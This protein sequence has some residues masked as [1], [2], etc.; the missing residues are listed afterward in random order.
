LTAI[1]CNGVNP[2][3]SAPIEQIV[4]SG[5]EYVDVAWASHGLVAL[6]WD[7]A[8]RG[9]PTRPALDLISLDSDGSEA[10]AVD[11]WRQCEEDLTVS[12][13]TT[14]AR[15][16]T[17][18][19]LEWCNTTVG[20]SSQPGVWLLDGKGN[21]SLLFAPPIAVIQGGQL[22]LTRDGSSGFF[23]TGSRI[24]DG[25]LRIDASR[26]DDPGIVIS[27]DR[28]G[29]TI[30]ASALG[31]SELCDSGQ[32][33]SPDIS[34]DGKTLALFASP[35][36]VRTTG[37]DRL[38]VPFDIYLIDLA[39]LEV[40]R[41]PVSVRD[42]RDLRWSPVGNRLAFTGNVDGTGRSLTVLELSSRRR[43]VIRGRVEGG[44]SWS[45]DA[46]RIASIVSSTPDQADAPRR[47]S[48][49]EVPPGS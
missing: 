21:P 16:D 42:P 27:G 45:P 29:F 7:A 47:I 43:T 3:V 5:H 4:G 26:A 34:P 6:R 24:C 40:M 31:T 39:S 36:A 13:L 25:V 17:V 49:V 23:G 20:A 2:K 41:I 1:A 12:S 35:A 32:A 19:Y 15:G 8:G 11:H 18:A 48:V 9:G 22:T 14:V 28:G 38:E 10:I 33:R 46:S 44:M 30:G 37:L